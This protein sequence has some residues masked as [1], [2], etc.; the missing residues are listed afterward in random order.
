MNNRSRD[1]IV[2]PCVGLRDAAPQTRAQDRRSYINERARDAWDRN[3]SD[4]FFKTPPFLSFLTPFGAAILLGIHPRTST[5]IGGRRERAGSVDDDDRPGI[6]ALDARRNRPAGLA[7][8]QPGGDAHQHRPP[9]PAAVRDRRLLGL[10]ARAG[11]GEP[12]AGRDD[13]AAP[14]E[15][16]PRPHAAHRGP[17]RP[18]RRA[19]AAAGRRRRH[20]RIRASSTS[21]RRARIRIDSFL[22][23]PVI[24]RGLLQGVLVVQTDR[25]ARPSARTTCGCW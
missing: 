5:A 22:G 20:A 14:R 11:S 6:A 19:A 25:A 12:G 18:G 4:F 24:D 3:V 13:R 1:K 21:A 7:Q 15:R 8:R 2:L 23:V 16:R 10:P 17:G 9:D